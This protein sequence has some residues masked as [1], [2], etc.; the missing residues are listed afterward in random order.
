MSAGAASSPRCARLGRSPVAAVAL[1]LLWCAG[2]SPARAQ[3]LTPLAL[4]QAREQAL[5]RFAS[6]SRWRGLVQSA[7]GYLVHAVD[8]ERLID[9]QQLTFED[10]PSSYAFV[11]RGCDK[12]TGPARC[13]EVG[14]WIV[15]PYS[16]R[17]QQGG[18]A[19]HGPTDEMLPP[20]PPEQAGATMAL[21]GLSPGDPPLLLEVGETWLFWL[22]SEEDGLRTLVDAWS[23]D[24]YTEEA[25]IDVVREELRVARVAN[26]GGHAPGPPEPYPDE[27][28]PSLRP[29]TQE[30]TR[31]PFQ[32]LRGRDPDLVRAPETRTTPADGSWY[33]PN[34]GSP[35]TR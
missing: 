6:S 3:G 11:V 14:L 15:D 17:F 20:L 32:G 10:R 28:F 12:G 30:Q 18:V 7:R 22:F 13:R 27:P 21:H 29:V 31:G 24:V 8:E 23:G 34:P 9:A 26:E 25:F 19:S 33:A 16:G 1:G 35:P 4:E 2:P 5:Q